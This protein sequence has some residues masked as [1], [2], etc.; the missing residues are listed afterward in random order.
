ML[1][2][3]WPI[4]EKKA[5]S[6]FSFFNALYLLLFLHG[7]KIFLNYKADFILKSTVKVTVVRNLSKAKFKA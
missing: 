1:L 2:P 5:L 4:K 6:T 3:C 7:V